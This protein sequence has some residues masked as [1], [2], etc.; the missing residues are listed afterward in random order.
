MQISFQLCHRHYTLINTKVSSKAFYAMSDKEFSIYTV[1]DELRNDIDSLTYATGA[2][3]KDEFRN[4]LTAS[5]TK[6]RVIIHNQIVV[7][8][9]PRPNVDVRSIEDVIKGTIERL[10]Y[11]AAR[12]VPIDGLYACVH[13]VLKFEYS[14]GRRRCLFDKNIL[15]IVKE[16]F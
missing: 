12:I 14:N 4:F 7:I 8:T 13:I 3:V 10:Q 2:R 15:R 9:M 16:F 1:A 5:A 6:L 11:V